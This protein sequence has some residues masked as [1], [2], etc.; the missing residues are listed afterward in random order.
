MAI[1]YKVLGQEVPAANVQT[2]V[3]TVPSGANTVVSTIN[4]CNLLTTNAYFR[5]AVQPANASIVSKHYIAYDAPL[6]GS[7]S[8]AL[9]IGVTLGTTDVIS[10]TSTTGNV[11]FNVFGTEIV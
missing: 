3:Y 7:D 1:T 5:I 6:P 9:T 11:A 2:T 4:I 10:A 8:I